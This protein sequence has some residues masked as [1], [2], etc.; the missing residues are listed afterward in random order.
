MF[1]ST[2]HKVGTILT[3]VI[4]LLAF[5]LANTWT[6][7][8]DPS[9]IYEHGGNGNPA[10]IITLGIWIYMLFYFCMIFVFE[11]VHERVNWSRKVLMVIY[12]L[13]FFAIVAITYFRMISLYQEISPYYDYDIG[14]LNPY[15]NN[16]LFNMWTFIAGLLATA[17][18]SL[19]TLK[20]L[21]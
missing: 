21:R 18:I 14:L 9:A 10:L 2:W 5:W 15:S 11:A 13:L 16:L 4:T 1:S 20:K 8:F 12:P 6:A 19:F 7:T 17:F 3:G